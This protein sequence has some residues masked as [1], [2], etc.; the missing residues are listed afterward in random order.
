MERPGNEVADRAL[1]WLEGVAGDRFFGWVHLFDA[2]SPYDPPEPYRSRF[3]AEPY[4]GEIAFA[5]AQLA[6]LLAFLERRGLLNKT[7]IVVIGDHGESLGEHGESTHGFFAY[8]S[9]LEVPFAILAPPERRIPARRVADVVRS[10]DVAPTVLDLLNLPAADTFDG[11]SLV[12]LMNGAV[13]ELNLEAYSEAMYPRYHFGWSELRAL[14]AGRFKY[15]DAPRPEL[16]DLEQDPQETRNL[17]AARQPLADRMSNALRALGDTSAATA[18]PGIEGDAD[19]RERLAALGYVG[20]FSTNLSRAPS[21]LADPKDKVEMFNLI[22]RAREALQAADGSSSGLEMLQEV[23]RKDPEVIDAWLL[24]GNEYR[25]APGIGSRAGKLPP[26]PAGES[27][28]RPCSHE[29]GQRV[30]RSGATV[31]RARRAEAVRRRASGKRARAP[32]DGADSPR[33]R[34][35]CRCRA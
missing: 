14:T 10:V 6:R 3:A 19:A 29:H 11:T 31:G 30:S 18:S 12:P 25:E 33:H 15:I 5:D 9:V 7:V 28:L 26:R 1:E 21:L 8:Q 4:A 27:R 32:A 24:M 2:H 35:A 22:T 20:T 23:T 34:P 13:R 16:Y 17:Y